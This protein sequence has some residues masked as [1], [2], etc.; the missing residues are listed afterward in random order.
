M[1]TEFLD[2]PYLIADE[3]NQ[4]EAVSQRLYNL[5]I[6]NGDLQK[7]IREQKAIKI[8][9][10]LQ[11]KKPSS[12]PETEPH[13]NLIKTILLVVEECAC[14][15]KEEESISHPLKRDGI[16][17]RLSA[18]PID[19]QSIRIRKTQCYVEDPTTTVGNYV[20][21]LYLSYLSNVV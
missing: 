18:R 19:S 4:F 17:Q 3:K 7:T 1:L 14:Q 16:F 13:K 9:L 15:D 21:L 20:S 8:E 6:E 5:T 10:N 2:I 12:T 11:T